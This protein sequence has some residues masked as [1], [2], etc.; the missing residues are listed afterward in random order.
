MA[1][2]DC[3]TLVT[4]NT[5]FCPSCGGEIEVHPS[6]SNHFVTHQSPPAQKT[7]QQA[8]S[9]PGTPPRGR[10]SILKLVASIGCLVLVVGSATAVQW[11]RR[12]NAQ[13]EAV[14]AQPAPVLPAQ[15][16]L[17]NTSQ[18]AVSNPSGGINSSA[19]LLHR[20]DVLRRVR[21]MLGDKYENLAE[22]FGVEGSPVV[23]QDTITVSGCAPHACS[24]LE[25][26]LSVSSS[27]ALLVA[28]LLRDGRI[29]IYGAPDSRLAN[30][31]AAFQ[32]WVADALEH[33]APNAVPLVFAA[34]ARQESVDIPA[35]A[36]A[37]DTALASVDGNQRDQIWQTILTWAHSIEIADLDQSRIFYADQLEQY[38]GKSNVSASE[39]VQTIASKVRTY[40]TLKFRASNPSFRQ[41]APNLVQVDYDKLYEF[42]APNARPNEGYTKS[43]LRLVRLG[44]NWDIV[45]EF[46]RQVCWSTLMRDPALQSPP[47]TCQ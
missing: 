18:I 35:I 40:T 37:T 9:V 27:S 36:S 1:C 10:V 25:S 43:S 26:A 22:G 34:S 7:Y 20:P 8:C 31:P 11:R 44:D 39:V 14:Q 2:D 13:Q 12:G 32:K 47:G 15:A 23:T 3:G 41:L 17:A 38:Y 6:N 29:V 46:D 4:T 33:N 30:T 28:G 19:D 5:G 24:L 16:P 21:T 45:A 42:T